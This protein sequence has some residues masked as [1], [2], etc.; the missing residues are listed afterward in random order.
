M[1]NIRKYE[2]NELKLNPPTQV[3]NFIY[4]SEFLYALILLRQD[5]LILLHIKGNW[6]YAIVYFNGRYS[7]ENTGNFFFHPN[8]LLGYII[9][10]WYQGEKLFT[11][12][13]M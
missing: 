1:V 9:L 2:E 5:C 4:K 8:I 10:K 13:M 12:I 11:I 7:Y 3:G 6:F